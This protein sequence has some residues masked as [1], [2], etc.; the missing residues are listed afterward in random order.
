MSKDHIDQIDSLFAGVAARLSNLAFRIR[1][2]TEVFQ[3]FGYAVR[4]ASNIAEA[5]RSGEV[6]EAAIARAKSVRI[7]RQ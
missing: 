7:Q 3:D 2:V 1:E 5:T 6:A 4:I